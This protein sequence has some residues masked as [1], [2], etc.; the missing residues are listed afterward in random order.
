M[1]CCVVCPPATAAAPHT[2]FWGEELLFRAALSLTG[3]WGWRPG[4]TASCFLMLVTLMSTLLLALVVPSR[5]LDI[6]FSFAA[7]LLIS[8]VFVYDM[9]LMLGGNHRCQVGRDQPRYNVSTLKFAR[10]GA[11]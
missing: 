8:A 1:S 4:V 7:A 6:L 5:P 10:V 9:Q 3:G 11:V 2:A